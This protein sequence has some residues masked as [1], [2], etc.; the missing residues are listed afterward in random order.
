MAPDAAG[1]A[2]PQ[3]LDRA[4][5]DRLIRASFPDLRN[6]YLDVSA[7]GPL[8][9]AARRAAEALLLQRAEGSVRKDDWLALADRTRAK[10]AQLLRV[11]PEDV[12]FVKNTS[13][14]LNLVGAALRLGKGDRMVVAPSYEH[15]NNVFPWLWHARQA[16]A[17]VVQIGPGDPAD[18]EDR[19]IAAIDDRTRL[20]AV[21]A[22]D[23]ASGRRTDLA[24]LAPACRRAGAF[25]LA[26]AAQS[27][28]VMDEPLAA[29]GVDG[30]ATAAQKGLL[31]L[32]GIGLLYV[33]REWADRMEPPFLARFSVEVPAGHEA[34]GPE[35]GWHLRPGAG[36]F[37]CGNHNYVG[38]AALEASLD[39]LNAIGPG[40]VERRAT[41]AAATLRAGIE[42]MG[43]SVL[44]LPPARRAHIVSVG[45]ALGAGHDRTDVTWVQ[46]L[47][48]HLQAKGVAH[49]VR[50]GIL[51]LSTHVHM[52]PEVTQEALAHIKA[53]RDGWRG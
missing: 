44:P 27:S 20:V 50:R 29:L 14:G 34:A 7:R 53:W 1:G 2:L 11:A 22:L 6:P 45:E 21:T 37:E 30:W 18:L 41:E 4:A 42:A 28:G 9:L 26:D 46:A 8:P 32:Y 35:G 31:G 16:G 12:A 10:A 47:S 52:L 25:L 51:R 15:P 23:F 49:S 40:E 36:R 43:L 3:G 24:R 39:L 5:A 48:T 38:L 13:E 19:I 33:R 17:E